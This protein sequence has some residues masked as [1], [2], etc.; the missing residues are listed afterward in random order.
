MTS[1]RLPGKVL[2]KIMNKYPIIE[3]IYLRVMKSKLIDN[4][5]VATTNKKTDDI[6]VNF[7]KKKKFNFF[8]GE[9]NN[10]LKRVIDTGKYYKPKII[11]QLTG[12]NPFLDFKIIDEMIR[13]FLKKKCDFLT[14]NAFGISE[15]RKF[16][17][18]MT[19]NIF[20]FKDLVENYEFCTTKELKEHTSLYF[21]REGK[22]KFN[23]NNMPI[24]KKWCRNFLP[25]LTVDEISDFELSNKIFEHF[26]KKKRNIYFSYK[27]ILDFLENNQNLLKINSHIK[28]KKFEG[29]NG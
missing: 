29:I 1:K 26:N 13:Y 8:R 15:N 24:K 5:C 2:K 12:D 18:G 7:L 19:I 10:V 23:I 16:P 17:H 3:V 27:K 20:Y 25:R 14:N 6:L 22:K 4:I 9:E 11:V 28:Q 21:F